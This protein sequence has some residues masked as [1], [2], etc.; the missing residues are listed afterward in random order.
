M[1]RWALVVV[2]LYL[3]ILAVL[4]V[5]VILLAFVPQASAKDVAQAYLYLPFWLWLGVMGLAQAALLVVPVRVAN[6]RPVARRLLLWPVVTAGAMMGCLVMGAMYSLG[7]FA[8]RDKVPGW[9]WWAGIG[10]GVIIWC[11]WA[12]LFY[13]SSRNAEPTDVVSRQCRLL[14]RGSILEL[15]VAVPTHIV[16]R[17]REYCCAGA[18]TFIGLAL[19]ISV[20]L[21]SFG[22][23]VFFLYAARWRRLHPEPQSEV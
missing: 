8:A 3:L 17:S 5:P 9:F 15:L 1:K 14:L 12:V 10:S 4:T 20:M 13:R 19:G 18:M 7:E 21:F 6:Q 23:S 16:A 2:V 11:V 22:P